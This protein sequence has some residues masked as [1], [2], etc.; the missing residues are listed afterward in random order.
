MRHS[1][2]INLKNKSIEWDKLFMDYFSGM[3]SRE[4]ERK[5]NL[6]DRQIRRQCRKVMILYIR[7][8]GRFE[9]SSMAAAFQ[10]VLDYDVNRLL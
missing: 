1:G 9:L 10:K 7:E 5:Y 8:G 6:S 4:M 2:N 3:S